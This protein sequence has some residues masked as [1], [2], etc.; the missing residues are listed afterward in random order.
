MS[1]ITGLTGELLLCDRIFIDSHCSFL[2]VSSVNVND[3]I[4][5]NKT[6]S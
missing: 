3:E 5:I 6:D 1:F 4:F 2:F